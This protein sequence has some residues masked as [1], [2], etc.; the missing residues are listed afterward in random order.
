MQDAAG[1]VSNANLFSLFVRCII[2]TAAKKW[3]GLFFL[4]T[5]ILLLT[6]RV[7][8]R[9]GELAREVGMRA[10]HRE[11]SLRLIKSNVLRLYKSKY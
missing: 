6:I 7:L 4:T 1:Y 9:R 10:T 5:L 3:V 2:L 8:R 11:I